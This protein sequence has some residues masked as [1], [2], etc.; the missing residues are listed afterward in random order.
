MVTLSERDGER[1]LA[2][3]DRAPRP[4]P[5]ALTKAKARR[6]TL[7]AVEVAVWAVVVTPSAAWRPTSTGVSV[8]NRC[9]IAKPCS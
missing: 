3:L 1:F 4:V 6:E 8:L 9:W 5:G 7:L 2:A